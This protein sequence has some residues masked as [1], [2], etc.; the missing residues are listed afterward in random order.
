M[1]KGGFMNKIIKKYLKY[2]EQVFTFF[3][4]IFYSDAILI[5]VLSNGAG[6]S[7]VELNYDT[8]LY[9]LCASLIYTITFLL[10]I[11][12]WKTSIYFIKMNLIVLLVFFLPL[13]SLLWSYSPLNTLKDSSALLGSSI[14]GIYFAS[15]YTLKQQLRLL[16]WVFC[17][18]VILCPIFAIALPKYGMMGSAWRGIYLHKN[19]LGAS[20]ALS[21]IIFL[22]LALSE[23]SNRWKHCLFCA[24]SLFLL[25][26]SQSTSALLNLSFSIILLA[27]FKILKLR[28]HIMIPTFFL[29]IFLSSNLYL[30]FTYSADTIFEIVGK[31]TTL[32]GRTDIWAAAF[33]MIVKKPWLGYGYGGFW[34]GL[35]SESAY[36]W[37]STNWVPTHPHNGFIAI[38]LDLGLLGLTIFFLGYLKTLFRA[39]VCVRYNIKKEGVWVLTF[40]IYMLLVNTTESALIESNSLMWILYISIS[41]SLA[42]PLE[43]Q[44]T[45]RAHKNEQAS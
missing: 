5:L 1:V 43:H 13:V 12:R 38:W 29:L 23:K 4:L 7:D 42:I 40:L 11:I 32:T 24:F 16:G 8:S 30:W 9:R 39:I 36:I 22:F 44:T 28:Y 6:Q 33:D 15:R 45:V 21:T 10:L 20:M 18:S 37:R 14:F 3:S 26:L 2:S 27:V 25:L 41:F 31:D 35:N 19:G 17:I 34:Y